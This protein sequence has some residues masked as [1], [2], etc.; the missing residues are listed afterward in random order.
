MTAVW[1]PF[2]TP[3]GIHMGSQAT[4]LRRRRR[5]LKQS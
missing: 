2:L 5:E 3:A 1:A 4:G